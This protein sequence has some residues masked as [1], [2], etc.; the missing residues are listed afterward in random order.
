VKAYLDAADSVAKI[1]GLF[2]PERVEIINESFAQL[3]RELVI[4]L[5]D[6]IRDLPLLSQVVNALRAKFE[7]SNRA[8]LSTL[9]DKKRVG[10]PDVVEPGQPQIYA[11]RL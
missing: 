9:E 3:W 1:E 7:G 11:G 8:V 2:A 10:L 4:V 6:N 5:R